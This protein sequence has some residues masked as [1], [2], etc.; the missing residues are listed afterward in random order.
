ML[1]IRTILCATDFSEPAH[2]AF[3]LASSVARDYRARL[4]ALHVGLPEVIFVAGVAVPEVEGYQEELLQRLNGLK[5]EAPGIDIEP[6][7]VIS[8]KPADEILRIARD[9]N[10][11]LLVLGTHGRTGLGRMLMGSVAE[12]V[13]R[14]AECPII[15][16]KVPYIHDVGQADTRVSDTA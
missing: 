7:L 1:P 8:D 3:R 13:V 10:C 2:L 15:T 4:I 5:A 16:V 11:D 12:H 6:R 14:K 9:S